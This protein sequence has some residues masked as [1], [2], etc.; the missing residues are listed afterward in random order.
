[1][2]ADIAALEALVAEHDVVF[3]LMDT[4]ESRWLPTLLCAASPGK[5][6][7]NAALGFDGYMVM[8]HGAAVPLPAAAAADQEEDEPAAVDAAAAAVAAAS[9]ADGAALPGAALASAAAAAPGAAAGLQQQH[10]LGC[11]FCNDVVAPLNSTVDRTLDQQCTVARPGLSAIAGSLAV[12]L[13][14]AVRQHPA[15][16]A[17]PASPGPG[18]ATAVLA[19]VAGGGSAEE[20]P[21]GAAP[22]MVRGQLTGFSQMCLTGQAFRQCTACSEAVVRQYRQR[23]ADFVLQ[24][25]LDPSTLEDLTGLTELHRASEAS[26]EAWEASSEEEEEG[27]VEGGAA[28]PGAGEGWEE[29]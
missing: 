22:H 15:G 2:R 11:Y 8:R 7:I 9:I 14:A 28:P 23:G 5:L 4:R 3:L 18:S 21:L 24:G 25:L 17:A 29:L 27:A 1:M 20:L 19:S 16:A 10:R 26:L 6:A 13:M 12:E